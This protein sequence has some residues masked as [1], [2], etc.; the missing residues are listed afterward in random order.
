VVGTITATGTRA[1]TNAGTFDASTSGNLC[2]KG[3]FSTINLAT[4]DSIQ[5]TINL[6]FT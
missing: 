5:F 6:Q 2:V 1:V 4:N 3:D